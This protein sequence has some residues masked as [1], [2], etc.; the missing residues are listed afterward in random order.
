M[1]Q[2]DG[3]KHTYLSVEHTTLFTVCGVSGC[4]GFLGYR[5]VYRSSRQIG[6]RGPPKLTPGV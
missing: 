3:S 4:D 6:E 2:D 1:K 5:E